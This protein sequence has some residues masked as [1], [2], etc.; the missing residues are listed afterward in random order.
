VS[1]PTANRRPHSAN[2]FHRSRAAPRSKSDGHRNTVY[3][4]ITANTVCIVD[5]IDDKPFLSFVVE[6]DNTSA[7]TATAG[8]QCV[9]HGCAS[10]IRV[11]VA[12]S[13]MN[14]RAAIVQRIMLP[15]ELCAIDRHT[16]PNEPSAS[17]RLMNFTY[18]K[19]Q[20][21]SL[22]GECRPC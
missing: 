13:P 8:D 20:R 14:A 15:D 19:G 16:M 21:T 1:A 3:L 4:E 17:S 22:S 7:S 9:A 5:V 6:I 2:F 18:P 12:A 11:G 10:H